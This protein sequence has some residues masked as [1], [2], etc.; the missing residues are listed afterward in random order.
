MFEGP[1]PGVPFFALSDADRASELRA[2][3]DAIAD[4]A[5]R[6]DALLLPLT[7]DKVWVI[8]DDA[9]DEGDIVA[10]DGVAPERPSRE[11]ASPSPPRWIPA[12]VPLAS[13]PPDLFPRS[14]LSFLGFK[15]G[16]RAR[17]APV[18]CAAVADADGDADAARAALE[19]AA[20]KE[21]KATRRNGNGNG[22]DDVAIAVVDA[23]S[24]GPSMRRADAALLSAAAGLARWQGTVR[25]CASCGSRTRLVKAGHKAVCAR[26]NPAAPECRGA[27][28]P[29]LMP[30]V[31][32]L[33]TCG[34]YALLGRNSRWPRGFYSCLAGFVDQSESL[35]QAVAREVFE[36]SGVAIRPG[37]ASYAGSQPWP[38]PCQLM[39]G[40]TAEV[41]PMRAYDDG[42][43][44]RGGA[45]GDAA[46][47]TRANASNDPTADRS[48]DRSSSDGARL[49]LLRSIPPT[50][51]LD[52]NEL[53]DARWF[54]RDW[55]R[56]QLGKNEDPREGG[57]AIPVGEIALP[58]RHAL[59]RH[60]VERWVGE[61]EGEAEGAEKAVLSV[62]MAGGDAPPTAPPTD[63]SYAFAIAEMRAGPRGEGAG[64]AE[65]DADSAGSSAIVMRLHASGGGGAP[66]AN[67][68]A[69][70][71]AA[72]AREAADREAGM[73]ATVLGAGQLCFRGGE[74]SESAESD[75]EREARATVTVR[76]G[77]GGDAGGA[78]VDAADPE[79]V[80]ALL[81][82]AY[83]MHEAVLL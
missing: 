81:R 51:S 45:R 65:G 76:V 26:E 24:A 15:N 19:T 34:D 44:G 31:L 37:S 12:E 13:I 29:K 61:G 16:D 82:R 43:E 27:F 20:A 4:A 6:P 70:L 21:W 59:A 39:V 18:F 63:R 9:D 83:P 62:A 23:K 48:S 80:L 8:L 3:A 79:I 49:R 46:G 75:D 35:E 41:P 53:R 36:E 30:A 67:D 64:E 60:L 71:R 57:R 69:R 77:G 54:H 22:T 50:P 28:Y 32:A 78:E 58:G 25:F 55:L 47:G 74:V 68:H 2:D 73:V 1:E 33:C 17:G 7:G 14:K 10:A 5:Q 56:A 11:H 66:T 38:F 72:V 40:F 42:S 52:A